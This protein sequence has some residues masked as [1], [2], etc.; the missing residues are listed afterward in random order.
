MLYSK[1]TW[2]YNQIMTM[3]KYTDARYCKY[4]KYNVLFLMK[5]KVDSVS[6]KN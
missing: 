6:V 4:M 5:E 3:K 1:F 2:I